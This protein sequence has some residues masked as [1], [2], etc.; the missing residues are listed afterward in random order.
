MIFRGYGRQVKG[1]WSLGR[2]RASWRP[3]NYAATGPI[4]MGIVVLLTRSY[5]KE[6]VHGG[7]T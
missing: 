1:G 5:L 7:L 3:F 4:D 6:W 2:C